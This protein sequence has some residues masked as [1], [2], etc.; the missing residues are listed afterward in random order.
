MLPLH[1]QEKLLEDGSMNYWKFF[2]FFIGQLGRKKGLELGRVLYV[3]YA[4]DK[5][6][7]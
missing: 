1:F 4:E 6:F 2:F 3:S 7:R 5:I